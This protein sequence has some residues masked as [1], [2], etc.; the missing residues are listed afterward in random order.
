MR[1]PYNWIPWMTF[2]ASIFIFMLLTTK[3]IIHDTAVRISVSCCLSF[4]I[5]VLS[6]FLVLKRYVFHVTGIE[7]LPWGSRSEL[8]PLETIDGL[9]YRLFYGSAPQLHVHHTDQWGN[10]VRTRIVLGTKSREVLSF[11]SSHC[12]VPIRGLPRD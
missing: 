3:G 10:T 1:V 2:S 4:A 6:A 8:I 11:L 5:A 7:V 12:R 9:T